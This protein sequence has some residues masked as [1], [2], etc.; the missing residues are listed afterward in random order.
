M[1]N[2]MTIS[3]PLFHIDYMAI[4]GAIILVKEPK[5][6]REV[7]KVNDL[8]TWYTFFNIL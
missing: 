4:K 7:Y 2:S 1:N 8:L 5:I 6:G 3:M